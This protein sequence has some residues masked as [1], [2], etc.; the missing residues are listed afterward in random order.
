MLT[1]A[2]SCS[3]TADKSDDQI[4]QL[5]SAEEMDA[6]LSLD[7]VQLIDV[8]TPEE[9]E[10]GH[11][12]GAINIDYRDS[13]F[14]Q[15]LEQIDKTKPI[16]IYCKKGGRSNACAMDMKKQGF[17]KIYDLDGGITQWIYHG[18]EMVK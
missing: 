2:T 7:K 10:G 5:L 14:K 12:E 11:I 4:I 6:I 1:I 13:N 17:V 8:R 9:F 15:K 18:K 3:R 16:A